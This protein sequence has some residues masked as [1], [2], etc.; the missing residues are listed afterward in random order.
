MDAFKLAC[1]LMAQDAERMRA[2]LAAGVYEFQRPIQK[3]ASDF[4][5]D[6][7]CCRGS[8]PF[9]SGGCL[10]E[11]AL[12]FNSLAVEPPDSDHAQGCPACYYQTW[13]RPIVVKSSTCGHPYEPLLD[14]EME[15]GERGDTELCRLCYHEQE[16]AGYESLA[17]DADREMGDERGNWR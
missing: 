10:V 16:I 9:C 12:N 11:K 7:E 1:D 15:S 2:R 13:R 6:G 5:A 14:Y 3:T 8:D 17:E 4:R